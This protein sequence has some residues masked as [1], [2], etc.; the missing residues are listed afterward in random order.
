[1][2]EAS[3]LE[4]RYVPNIRRHS[5]LRIKKVGLYGNPAYA[6]AGPVRWWK[7]ISM[8]VTSDVVICLIR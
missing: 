2:L 6:P 8:A 3:N 4:N 5:G 7:G 1:M